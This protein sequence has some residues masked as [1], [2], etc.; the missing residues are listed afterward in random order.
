MPPDPLIAG[1]MNES[2]WTNLKSD[3]PDPMEVPGNYTRPELTEEEKKMMENPELAELN[4][5]KFDLVIPDIGYRVTK[6]LKGNYTNDAWKCLTIECLCP[7]FNGTLTNEN[8]CI[9]PSGKPLTKATR[10]EYRTMT[11]D[12]RHRYHKAFR[13]LMET[14]IFDEIAVIHLYM[15]AKTH[16]KSVFWTWH[17]GYLKK[18]EY[19][20]RKI[21]SDLFVPYWD[22]TL[23]QFLP[24]PADSIMWTDDF[25]GRSDENGTVIS[26]P[27][28]HWTTLN[29]NQ[30][31]RRKN[32]LGYHGF[33]FHE[34]DLKALLKTT[35]INAKNKMDMKLKH[36][37]SCSQQLNLLELLHASAHDFVGGDMQDLHSA[38]NDPVFYQLH[39]FIDLILEI[40]K[41]H[42]DPNCILPGLSEFENDETYEFL[43]R[44]TC[45]HQ[46]PDCGSKY[47][48]CDKTKQHPRCTSKIR[49]NGNCTGFDN[50][51]EPCLK[52][53]CYE[54]Q[55]LV[56][57][58]ELN[59]TELFTTY[60]Y[61][62]EAPKEE[63]QEDLEL[64]N[65][66]S[67]LRK[68]MAALS[69]G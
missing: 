28:A 44:P 6:H 5:A 4:K 34:G 45:S 24:N 11:D 53:K 43:P 68:F 64:F 41:Q 60:D 7:H 13:T 25:M 27:A 19:E 54:N 29:S 47:L 16:G 55:C 20:L 37:F 22:T 65:L 30:L 1:Y 51:D 56:N 42:R 23:D 9:L 8:K 35:Q 14:G 15:V 49:H 18:L 17:R 40:W 69:M 3:E 2:W 32:W 36:K 59:S 12:E 21:D 61:F 48:F 66:S 50:E 46:N 57:I 62:D 58:K 39:S 67:R 52:E 26:G 31:I 10:K 63:N 33:L 38:S